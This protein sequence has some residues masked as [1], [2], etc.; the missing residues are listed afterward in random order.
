MRDPP[1]VFP[2]CPAH[3]EGAWLCDRRQPGQWKALESDSLG[4]K[5]CFLSLSAGGQGTG[6]PASAPPSHPASKRSID[7]GWVLAP[8]T[9]FAQPLCPSGWDSTLPSA[10]HTI[11]PGKLPAGGDSVSLTH[12]RT[13]CQEPGWEHKTHL[14]NVF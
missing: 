7:P 2:P 8:V 4:L 12:D 14:L 1:A 3:S 5:G 13:L 10:T 9:S 11:Q 6:L